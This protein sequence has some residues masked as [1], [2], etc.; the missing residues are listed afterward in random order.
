MFGPKEQN[1]SLGAAEMPGVSVSSTSLGSGCGG[2]RCHVRQVRVEI[3][4][5]AG[6]DSR[7]TNRFG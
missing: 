1:P 5:V 6:S 7:R 4:D 2:L 3:A